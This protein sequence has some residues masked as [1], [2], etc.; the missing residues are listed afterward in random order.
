M[1][2]AIDGL[3]PPV[4]STKFIMF[5]PKKEI[6]ENGLLFGNYL[7]KKQGFPTLYLG[8]SFPAEELADVLEK[9]PESF[10]FSV[11][12]LAQTDLTKYYTRIL[13][14]CNENQKLL[15][16]GNQT[17]TVKINDPRVTVFQDYSEFKDFLEQL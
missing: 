2:V 16:A 15:L 7:A 5:L 9:N 8:A 12:S 14:V 11:A 17:N 13:D 4:K 6:Q 3:A 1:Y 10:L